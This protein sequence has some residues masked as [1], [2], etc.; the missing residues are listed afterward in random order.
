MM[1][2][3]TRDPGWAMWAACRRYHVSGLRNWQFAK[4]TEG[5]RTSWRGRTW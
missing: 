1:G 2:A 5:Q 3:P 4:C